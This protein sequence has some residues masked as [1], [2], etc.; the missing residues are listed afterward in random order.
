MSQCNGASEMRR[1]VRLADVYLDPLLFR[2][3]CCAVLVGPRRIFPVHT[4]AQLDL[5]RGC[6]AE[7]EDRTIQRP[8]GAASD[9]D[10]SHDAYSNLRSVLKCLRVVSE[11]GAVRDSLAAS[12]SHHRD[13][14]E[15]YQCVERWGGGGGAMQRTLYDYCHG[16]TGSQ[17][18]ARRGGRGTTLRTHASRGSASTRVTRFQVATAADWKKCFCEFHSSPPKSFFIRFNLFHLFVKAVMVLSSGLLSMLQSRT[19]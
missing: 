14:N 19:G 2:D 12:I 15:C 6:A 10:P 4:P 1:E 9:P 3:C 17:R 13:Y 5:R 16:R 8:E 11:V 18:A 7:G